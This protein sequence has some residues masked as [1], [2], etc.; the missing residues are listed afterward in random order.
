MSNYIEYED[1]VAFHPG[2]YIEEIIEDSGLNQ[3]DFAKR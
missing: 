1:T 2:Y 3:K